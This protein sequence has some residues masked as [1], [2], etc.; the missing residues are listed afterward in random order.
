[1]IGS[2]IQPANR[3]Q[4]DLTTVIRGSRLDRDSVIGG[5][6]PIMSNNLN[7]IGG[8]FSAIYQ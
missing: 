7:K 3:G 5:G 4:A 8:R 6:G 1:M 2:I